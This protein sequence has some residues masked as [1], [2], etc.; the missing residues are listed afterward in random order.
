G[1]MVQI[2]GF[3]GVWMA[4]VLA[5]V[6]GRKLCMIL[7]TIIMLFSWIFIALF[8]TPA[9]IL[10]A[11][12]LSGIA[13]GGITVAADSY[14]T[15]VPDID[16]RGIMFGITSFSYVSGELLMLCL[17]Y[18][19]R[20]YT[21]ALISAVLPAI[22]LFILFFIP[23]SPTL[24][25]LKG[26]E[27]P[28]RKLL[29]RLRGPHANIEDELKSY[30]SL[31]LGS[32]DRASWRG[33]LER[34]TLKKIAI[35]SGLFVLQAF[36][37]EINIMVNASRVFETVGSA[38]DSQLSAIIMMAMQLFGS[39]FFGMLLDR[40]GRKRTLIVSFLV[41]GLSLTPMVA[42]SYFVRNLPDDK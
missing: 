5:T 4:G 15:E 26:K 41:M 13:V 29:R 37:G 19:F 33:L 32:Q 36:S 16:V 39:L 23:E 31:N 42:W 21:V 24:L 35:I 27:E 22:F 20:Y 17:G 8:K 28:A 10:G 34:E 38:I 18:W 14:L 6:M 3:P 11:R 25:Y 1:S 30:R 9:A 40:F 12:V 7:F 2:A